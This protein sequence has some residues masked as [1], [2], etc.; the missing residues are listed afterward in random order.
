MADGE[1]IYDIRGDDSELEHDLDR[2]HGKAKKFGEGLKTLAGGTAKAIGAGFVAA[3]AAAT[4]LGVVAVNSAAD[5]DKA[6]KHF[7]AATGIAGDSLENY[8]GVLEKVYQKN[9][10]ESFEDIADQMAKM[11]QQGLTSLV[12]DMDEL[13]RALENTYLLQDTFGIDTEESLRGATAMMKQ[14][15]ISADEAY[16]LIAQGAQ[17]GLNQNGDLADQLAEYSVYYSDLGFSAEE[18]FNAIKTGAADGTFQIDYLNDAIKEFGIRSKDN[19][20]A[21]RGAFQALGLDADQ[22]TQSFATGGEASK[23]AFGQVVEALT[24]CEDQVKQNELG[25]A[26]F[27]TKWEDLGVDAVMAMTS[28]QGS[29]RATDDVLKDMAEARHKDLASMWDGLKRSFELLILPL[30][31]QLLPLLTELIQGILPMIEEHLPPLVEM[32]SAFAS[33]LLPIAG[34]I[35]PVLVEMLSAF[36]STFQELLEGMAPVIAGVLPLLLELLEALVEPLLQ[37]MGEVLPAFG[38][39]LLTIVEPL[40]QLAESILPVLVEVWNQTYSIMG[41]IIAEILPVFAE[42]LAALIEVVAPLAEDFFPL[43]VEVLQQL[44]PPIGELVGN[45]LPLLLNIFHL[46]LEPVIQLADNLFP[47]LKEVILA[48]LPAVELV[49]GIVGSLL[50]LF[51]CVIAEVLEGVM[52][53]IQLLVDIFS[54]SL[55]TAVEGILPVIDSVIQILQGLIEF[56]TGVFTGNWEKAWQGIVDIFDGIISGLAGL[57]KIPINFIID[58]I[59]SFLSGLSGIEIPDWVPVVG[60]KSFSIPLIPRLKGG[61]DFVP[62]D[63]MPAYLDYGERVLTQTQNLKFNALGGLEGMERALSMDSKVAEVPKV[64]LEKG[65]I[66]VHSELDGKEVGVAM[67]PYLDRE[68]GAMQERKERGS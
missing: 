25:V 19:S 26:L 43:L 30:G 62:K 20:E 55:K 6:M 28:M 15:G 65:C 47:L 16:N 14:F 51:G 37:L 24:A 18:M 3:G 4:T 11:E 2:A 63:F 33:S 12:S 27:G 54:G 42:M 67:A 23:E 49:I 59:N 44:L 50:E 46:I 58:G 8:Q 66:I 21:T 1:V 34:E 60:G 9:Y 13:Q 40:L 41:Q 64:I 35:L 32:V 39:T 7:S 29:I 38:E 48:L 52:P 53:A 5:M 45:L 68:L 22:L 31:E 61:M 57:F 17:Q 56:I 36:A 10:G